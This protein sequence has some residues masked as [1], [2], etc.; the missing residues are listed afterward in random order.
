MPAHTTHRLQPLGINM[1]G[2]LSIAYS[3]ALERLMQ[4]GFGLVS[5]TKRLF[6]PLFH[7]AWTEAFTVE[8]IFHTF[9]KPGIFPPNPEKVLGIL[10]KPTI[11]TNSTIG[12]STAWASKNTIDMLGNSP[13]TQSLQFESNQAKFVKLMNANIKLAT[14]PSINAHVISGLQNALSIEKKKR[15]PGKRLNLISESDSRAQFWNPA[16]WE[17]AKQY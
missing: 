3:K 7:K 9:E 2:P 13:S 10:R 16:K 12:N 6:W 1:F 14:Q 5:M 17:T 15:R 8:R 4:Q 11:S